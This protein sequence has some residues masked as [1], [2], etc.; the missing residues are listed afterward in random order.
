[1]TIKFE[2]VMEQKGGGQVKEPSFGI[3]GVSSVGGQ[4][5]SKYSFVWE[6]DS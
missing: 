2:L 4:I 6:L 3:D 5:E 1:M